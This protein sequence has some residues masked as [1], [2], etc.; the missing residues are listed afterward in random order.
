MY[1]FHNMII[2]DE[3]DSNVPI[4]DVVDHL[5]QTTQMVVDENLIFEQF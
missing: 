2:E 4:Q 1:L 3:H 5:T